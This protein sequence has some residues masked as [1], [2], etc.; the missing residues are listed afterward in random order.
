MDKFPYITAVVSAAGKGERMGWHRNKLLIPLDNICILERTLMALV[1]VEEIRSYV[2][3]IRPEDREEI[4]LGILPR[5]FGRVRDH[6]I[7]A[8]GGPS[9]KDSIWNGL[10]ALPD[11]T[12]LV[13][14]HDGA[15]P[16]VTPE[17]IRRTIR[18]LLESRVDGSIC[19]VPVKDTVKV[20]NDDRNVV[21]T[22]NREKL[23]A[24]QTPQVFHRESILR[25][26]RNAREE[27]ISATDDAQIVELAGGKIRTV[28]GDYENIKI[29]TR[30]DLLIG[31]L[32]IKKR[33]DDRQESVLQP[34]TVK[35]N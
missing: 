22:P 5:V 15:R 30:E 28:R 2:I 32:I 24:V 9:R 7:L 18:G 8:P 19:V 34:E 33:L 27:D 13:L 1:A 12:D 14:Y 20:I 11:R 4:E 35:Q 31:E 26:Y 23:V 10:L 17:V 25:A 21:T 6:V 3:V 16:F 29:T